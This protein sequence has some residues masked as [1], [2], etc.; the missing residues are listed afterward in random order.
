MAAVELV[1]C[2]IVIAELC[3]AVDARIRSPFVVRAAELE[4]VS[5]V[6]I[7]RGIDRK[8]SLGMHHQAVASIVQDV[9]AFLAKQ[10]CGLAFQRTEVWQR[11]AEVGSEENWVIALASASHSVRHRKLNGREAVVARSHH[12]GSCPSDFCPQVHCL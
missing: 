9:F 7:C 2:V 1:L 11:N 4:P 6:D 8:L 10:L 5:A 12:C 3:G